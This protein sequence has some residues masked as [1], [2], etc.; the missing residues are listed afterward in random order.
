V[1]VYATGGAIHLLRLSNGEDRAL[2]LPNA[3]PALDAHLEPAGLFVSWN[4]M[5]DRRP[6]RMAFIP[7]RAIT[8]AL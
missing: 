2:R 6:G 5:H 8:R 4:K 1:A 3:A 7:L